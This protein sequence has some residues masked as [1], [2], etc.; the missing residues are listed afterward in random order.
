MDDILGI[1]L[2]PFLL[3]KPAYA[4]WMFLF[5]PEHRARFMED[6]EDENR[7]SQISMIILFSIGG[8]LCTLLAAVGIPI[9]CMGVYYLIRV[10]MN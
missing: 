6:I 1:L 10:C 3:L 4:F 9:V 7:I 5:S 2:F 8:I